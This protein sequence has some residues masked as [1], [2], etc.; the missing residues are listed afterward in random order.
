MYEAQL[1]GHKTL[2]LDSSLPNQN[3]FEEI[4][5]SKKKVQRSKQF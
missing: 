1:F 5:D 2:N 4:V 3:H